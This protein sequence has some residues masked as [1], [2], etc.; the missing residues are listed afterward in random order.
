MA[1]Y[2]EDTF[3]PLNKP[4]FNYE[5]FSQITLE[6]NSAQEALNNSQ[7]P[8]QSNHILLDH[9]YHK[10]FYTQSPLPPPLYDIFLKKIK[11]R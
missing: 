7:P 4:D 10:N 6:L 9:T 5:Y 2:V 1:K 11:C 3:Q 8:T